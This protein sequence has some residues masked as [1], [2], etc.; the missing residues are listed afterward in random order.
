MRVF[1][2]QS[3]AFRCLIFFLQEHQDCDGDIAACE[4]V[5]EQAD[6]GNATI[7]KDRADL[8]SVRGM[9]LEKELASGSEATDPAPGSEGGS[10]HDAV[11]E[12]L[13]FGLF[14]APTDSSC[15]HSAGG[16][17]EAGQARPK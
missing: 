1:S 11:P 4:V 13:S 9:L 12:F 15:H 6:A 2:P 10:H 16:Q 3:F 8:Q 14:D 17:A 5:F 7:M